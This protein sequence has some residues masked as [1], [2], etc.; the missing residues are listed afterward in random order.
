M[1]NSLM[2]ACVASLLASLSC[3][4]EVPQQKAL[5]DFSKL[6]DGDLVFIESSSGRSEAIKKLSKSVL[7]HCGIV[8]LNA[9]GKPEIYEGAGS[10]SD[11]HKPISEWQTDESTPK[12]QNK[13]DQPLHP[14]YARRLPGL[15]KEQIATLKAKA[16]ELHN[17]SYDKAFQFGNKDAGGKEYIYCSEFSFLVFKTIGVELG[18]PRTFKSFYT[19]FGSDAASIKKVKDTMAKELNST[20]AMKRRTPKDSE[21]SPDELVIAPVDVF[22]AKDLEPVE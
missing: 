13:P 7:S 11:T 22:K 19:V 3:A 1:T 17:T 2:L 14:V 12:D 5:T 4:Q 10:Y 6:K 20:E 15:T 18:T 16:T 21:Y 8:F 9:S